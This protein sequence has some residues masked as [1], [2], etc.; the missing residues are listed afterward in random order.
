MSNYI[1][2]V[3]FFGNNVRA[4]SEGSLVSLTDI[5]KA[6]NKWRADAVLPLKTL[7]AIVE[8]VGFQEFL[9]V[10]QANKPDEE[11][12]FTV[13]KGNQRRTMAH[14]ILAIYVAEQLSPEFHYK[15]IETFVEGKLLEF[16]ELGGTEFKNLNAAIDLYL[17]GRK[18]KDNKGVYITTAIA[19]R[20][21]LLGEN[22]V[23]SQW[24]EC[25]VAQTHSRYAAEQW[26]VKL[27]QQ[28]LV[29]DFEHLK[30]LISKV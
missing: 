9:K 10:T 26:L 2:Q 3:D 17:P 25:S 24:A 14:V 5:V 19:L 4:E 30:E 16:R 7:Q 8:S 18:G 27:L 20:K 28:G 12:F 22:A 13:G 1:M 29:R 15:V 23:S 21:K 6:G 11:V